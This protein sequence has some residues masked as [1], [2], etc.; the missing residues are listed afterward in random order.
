MVNFL[1]HSVKIIYVYCIAFQKKEEK[2]NS[3]RHS[4]VLYNVQNVHLYRMENNNKILKLPL[5]KIYLLLK[6]IPTLSIHHFI[7]YHLSSIFSLLSSI[8]YLLSLLIKTEAV[9]RTG[10][11]ETELWVD[12]YKPASC[13]GIIGQQGDW[14]FR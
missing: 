3:Y 13:K 14:A 6:N 2:K 10:P 12:K 4:P 7:I 8:F 11:I 5:Y 9:A 1:I